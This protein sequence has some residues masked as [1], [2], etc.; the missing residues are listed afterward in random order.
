LLVLDPAPT[1]DHF[2]RF[3]RRRGAMDPNS[4]LLLDEINKKFAAMGDFGGSPL[5][6]LPKARSDLDVRSILICTICCHML[7]TCVQVAGSKKNG[8]IPIF[9]ASNS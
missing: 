8:H 7:A 9:V 6:K 2:T 1:H 3:Q 4:K 5:G